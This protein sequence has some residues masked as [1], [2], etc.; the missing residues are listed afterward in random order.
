MATPAIQTNGFPPGYFIIRSVA[1]NRLLDVTQDDIEDGTE[2]ILWPEKEMSL[3]ESSLNSN[4]PIPSLYNY[5][6]D[7]ISSQ[8]P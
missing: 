8:E 6:C 1:T 7:I 5:P 4:H 3:V 2:I